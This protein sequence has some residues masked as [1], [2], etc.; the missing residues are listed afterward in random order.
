MAV[1][2]LLLDFDGTLLD[3]ELWHHQAWNEVLREHQLQLTEAEYMELIVGQ[4]TAHCAGI[5]NRHFGTSFD[6]KWLEGAV[7]A[8]VNEWFQSRPLPEM[9]G[10]ESLLHWSRELGLRT[11]VVTGSSRLLVQTA[12]ERTG[13]QEWIEVIVAD[14]E[15]QHGKPHPEGY[16]AA[17]RHL[18]LK[19]EEG[20]SIEDSATGAEA[21]LTAGLACL[22]LPNRFTDQQT[23]PEGTQR[24]GSLKEA[25]RWISERLGG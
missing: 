9:P 20:V 19:P 22:V 15:V 12:L 16:L 14:D 23:F 4:S 3:S 24:I 25:K 13:W 2:G 11:G 10:V 18:A 6:A 7:D 17:L 21:A 5:V 8:Q 1:K